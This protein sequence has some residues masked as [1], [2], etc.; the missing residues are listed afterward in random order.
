MHTIKD[1]YYI[2]R[3][4]TGYTSEYSILID[5]YKDMVY[6]ITY[7]IT[8]NNEDAE[9]LAQDVFV[10]AYNSLK[11]FKGRSKFST[12]LYSIAY[13]VT[14]D[15]LRSR[16]AGK[17]CVASL[18]KG[19]VEPQIMPGAD[20]PMISKE[21]TRLLRQRVD[22]LWSMVRDLPPIYR[23]VFELRY[24][25]WRPIARIAEMTRIPESNIK[26][27]LFRARRMLARAAQRTGM[28][29]FLKYD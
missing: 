16:S 2:N 9:E 13:H 14:I 29:Q 15:W 4:L 24:R 20:L 8:G 10:K 23:K 18:D 6:T 26:V 19:L 21:E 22:R 17:R 5:R 11:D 1:S 12:W 27:R 28:D 3:I 7:R 25:K